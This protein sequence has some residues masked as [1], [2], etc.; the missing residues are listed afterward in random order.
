MDKELRNM[1]LSGVETGCVD[2]IVRAEIAESKRGQ[3]IA[4]SLTVFTIVAAFVIGLVT[5]DAMMVSAFL[6]LPMV[7]IITHLFKPI[8]ESVRQGRRTDSV[9]PGRQGP[10]TDYSSY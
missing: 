8:A 10:S 1:P 3:I 4:A 2:E 7:G 6:A 5:R 9:R